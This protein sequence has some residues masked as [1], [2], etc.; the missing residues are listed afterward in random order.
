MGPPESPHPYPRILPLR[1]DR[2][3]SP[4]F[5][6]GAPRRPREGRRRPT[7]VSI[8][9]PSGLHRTHPTPHAHGA[10]TDRAL[11]Q[12]AGNEVGR[13]PRRGSFLRPASEGLGTG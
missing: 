2:G 6:P 8:R 9:S 5:T 12:P 7:I 4:D 3:G 11:P 13:K 1:D 10:A